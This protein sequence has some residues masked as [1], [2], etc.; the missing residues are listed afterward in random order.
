M[1]SSLIL[2]TSNFRNLI[3]F[4]VTSLLT[5]SNFSNLCIF[6]VCEKNDNTEGEGMGISLVWGMSQLQYDFICCGEL[7]CIN[8][9][10]CC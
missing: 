6:G 10:I 3:C 4:K 2:A 7:L 8:C 1:G 9:M 5:F